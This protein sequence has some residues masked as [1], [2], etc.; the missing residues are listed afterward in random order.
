VTCP[1]PVVYEW[2]NQGVREDITTSPPEVTIFF[3]SPLAEQS[4]RGDLPPPGC[5]RV[6]QTG[7]QRG[8][9]HQSTRGDYMDLL[10]LAQ[11]SQFEVTSVAPAGGQR[12]HYRQ[13][14][15]VTMVWY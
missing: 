5:L 8:H 9:H 15:E 1:R 14:A 3:P 4:V 2:L 13:S 12:G 10:F 7:G 6:A 11:V